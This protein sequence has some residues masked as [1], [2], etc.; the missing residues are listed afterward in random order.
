MCGVVKVASGPGTMRPVEVHTGAAAVPVFTDWVT[1]VLKSVCS[2]LRE[3]W[4]V[5]QT[6]P[7]PMPLR[8]VR[9]LGSAGMES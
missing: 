5:A 6:A 4:H 3:L 1:W 2:P 9:P 8:L 7:A